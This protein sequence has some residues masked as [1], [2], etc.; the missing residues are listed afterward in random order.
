MH[1]QQEIYALPV[2]IKHPKHTQQE[3]YA[4][5]VVIIHLMLGDANLAVLLQV[6]PD[7]GEG[8]GLLQSVG[9]IKEGGGGP[10]TRR[11]LQNQCFSQPYT[12]RDQVVM[13]TV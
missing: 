8:L 2:V 13:G 12:N 1:T 6:T 5:P 9:R 10:E 3:I 11:Q 4:L 7:P